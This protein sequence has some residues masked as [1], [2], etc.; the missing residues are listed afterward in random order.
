[1]IYGRLD[2]SK[3]SY[4]SIEVERYDTYDADTFDAVHASRVRKEGEAEGGLDIMSVDE[5]TDTVPVFE[6]CTKDPS[7][8]AVG[9]DKNFPGKKKKKSNTTNRGELLY[10][11]F[12][13]A[14]DHI[15]SILSGPDR[16][17]AI[18]ALAAF[19]GILCKYR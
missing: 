13:D 5:Y 10:L 2:A 17:K 11:W 3:T 18:E 1:M 4:F 6:F 14:M 12:N 16:E 9:V 7:L 15:I 19:E 8:V